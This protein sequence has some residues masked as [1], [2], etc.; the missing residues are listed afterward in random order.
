MS[1]GG[2]SMSGATSQGVRT[3]DRVESIREVAIALAALE[4][5][6][7]EPS[8]LTALL[9]RPQER[10]RLLGHGDVGDSSSFN[11]DSPLSEYLVT[12]LDLGRVEHWNKVLDQGVHDGRYIPV[13]LGDERYPR[14]LEDVWDA[15]P[16]L[17]L[18]AD[19]ANVIVPEPDVKAIAIVGGREVSA[20]VLNATRSVAG[21]IAKHGV[22]VVS[23]LALGVD[24]AAHWGALEAGGFTTA[25]VGTGIEQVFPSQNIQLAQ[26]ISRRGM[27][28]S[29]FPPGAP[30]TGT[31]FLRRNS[32]IA[33][34][35]VASL[36][37]DAREHSGSRHELE[38]ARRYGR[39]ILLWHPTLRHESWAYSLEHEGYAHFVKSADDVLLS[40][41]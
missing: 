39:K 34:M 35:T 23:G 40:L 30:R 8:D 18:S 19:H 16:F 5:I 37:M 9:R 31:T 29:Q 33:A 24:T 28:I 11:P 22:H 3:V 38:Q 32:V 27:L 13:L 15:P 1:S 2:A 26:E 7:G 4:L 20:G 36:V 21:R 6:P 12:N 14:Q 10:E 41:G 17:F 25:V